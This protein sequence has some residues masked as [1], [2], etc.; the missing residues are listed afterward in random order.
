M[1]HLVLCAFTTAWS[2]VKPWVGVL[3]WTPLQVGSFLSLTPCTTEATVPI[4]DWMSCV[5]GAVSVASA[6]SRYSCGRHSAH[7]CL[8]KS[9]HSLRDVSWKGH[10]LRRL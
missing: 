6:S 9:Q 5:S 10:S 2:Q 1:H 4:C 8:D 7:Q 3:H